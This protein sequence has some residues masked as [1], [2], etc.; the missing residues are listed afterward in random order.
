MEFAEQA[1]PQAGL[2]SQQQAEIRKD[3]LALAS[4][5]KQTLPVPGAMM[6]LAFL[7]DRGVE[8]YTYDWG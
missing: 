2:T 8:G 5:I 1:L 3:A 7:T 6:S 4:D